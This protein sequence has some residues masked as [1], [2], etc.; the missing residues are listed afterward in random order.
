MF[1]I[2]TNMLLTLKFFFQVWL[3]K[4]CLEMRKTLQLLTA[5]CVKSNQNST[6]GPDPVHF[7]SQVLCLSQSILFTAQ[8]EDAIRKGTL[9]SLLKS[10]KVSKSF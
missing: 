10:I 3:Q 1:N 8:C 7:P 6:G 5:E 9:H 4:L 2:K